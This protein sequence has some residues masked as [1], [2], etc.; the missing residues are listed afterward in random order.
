MG[1][2]KAQQYAAAIDLGGT[3]VLAAIVDKEHRVIATAKVRTDV[4]GGPQAVIEQMAR[5][6]EK[7]A[8]KADL[9]LKHLLA[10]GACAPG[11]VNPKTG[12]ITKAVNLGWDAPVSLGHALSETL[13]GL[14][15]LVDN[16]V[17]AGVYGEVV[18]GAA[19]GRQDVVGVFVG[20]GIGGGIVLDGVLRRGP[21]FGAGEIG[22]SIIL[23]DGPLCGCGNYGCIEAVASRT[24][25]ERTLRQGLEE[26]KESILPELLGG[27][28]GRMTSGVIAEAL[29]RKDP[30]T[31]EA[32]DRMAHYLGLFSASLVN[33][34]DPQMLVYGGGV[35]EKLGDRL[36]DPI[37]T[38]AEENYMIPGGVQIV[39]AQLSDFAGIIGIAA[40]AREAY[41]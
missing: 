31:A 14:P 20:T 2:K 3:K 33:I 12:I 29:E 30:L 4:D 1:K 38:V 9:K 11:P 35:V 17:N 28:E 15:V 41:R 18:A 6:V 39:P 10:A 27:K 23:A 26:G 7:A 32:I 16:D 24:A 37:R 25:L 5:A 21:R 36:L 40:L 19:Q 13:N 34:L 22:H 8:L